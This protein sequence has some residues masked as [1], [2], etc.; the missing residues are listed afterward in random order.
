MSFATI[1]PQYR[2]NAPLQ[3]NKTLQMDSFEKVACKDISFKGDFDGVK[4]TSRPFGLI[5]KTGEIANLYTITNKNGASVDLSDF[6]AAVISIKVPDKNG[7]IVDVA[8]GYDSVT[9]YLEGKTG[10]PGGTIGPVA[11]KVMNG[12]FSIDGQEYQLECNKDGGKTSSHG[13]SNGLD[14]KPWEAKVLKDGVK[15]TYYKKDGEGGHPG[16]MQINT[17]YKFDNNNKLTIEHSAITDKDTILNLTNHSYFNL[18]GVKNAQEDSVLE[19]VVHFPQSSHYTPADEISIPTGEIASVEG[20]PFDFTKPTKLSDAIRK[21]P[22]QL[23]PT[24]GGF[25]HNFCINGYNGKT[26]VRAAEIKSPETGIV[27]TV[28]TNLPGFQLYTANNLNPKTENKEGG[29]YEKRSALCIEPQFYPDAINTFDEKPI[30]IR[31]E[32]YNRQIT[33]AFS[34]L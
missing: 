12:T 6:G 17:T 3:L 11:S 18:G 31:G 13:A 2:L 8:Q 7:N 28:E 15:F 16:N 21:D 30:L 1:T 5:E 14:I 20:T 26:L 9:P 10:H 29:V 33:Y 4:I 23:K 25:D 19:H 24:S 34:A 32:T 27:L 22:E